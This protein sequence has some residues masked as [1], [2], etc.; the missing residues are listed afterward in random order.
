MVIRAPTRVHLGLIAMTRHS[1]RKYGGLGVALASPDVLVRARRD[2][3]RHVS[4]HGVEPRRAASLAA[5]LE[6]AGVSGVDVTLVHSPSHH[7]GLGSGTAV[8]LAVVEAAALCKGMLLAPQ[9]LV[10]VSGRGGTSG[11]GVN[12]YFTG[13]V[14]ADAG[15][16]AGAE[17]APS[18]SSTPATAPRVLLKLSWPPEW[19]IILAAPGGTRISAAAERRFFRSHA[20]LDRTDASEAAMALLLEVPA[21]IADHDF[22]G[23]REA[24]RASRTTGFKRREIEAQPLARALMAR[25]E[26]HGG[27]AATMSSLGPTVFFACSDETARAALTADLLRDGVAHFPGRAAYAGRV[28]VTSDSA[29]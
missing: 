20:Y 19:A 10:R 1:T 26:D 23:L 6:S 27:I 2:R 17:L 25:F 9:D 4:I 22:G 7:I 8:S 13:G 3:A 16:K 29:H 11:I 18:S 5:R 15:H 14:V 28:A 21:A 12:T 24:L